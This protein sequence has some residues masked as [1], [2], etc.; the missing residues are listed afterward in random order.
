MGFFSPLVVVVVRVSGSFHG[1]PEGGGAIPDKEPRSEAGG[2]VGAGGAGIGAGAGLAV[3][4]V[5]VAVDFMLADGI[6]VEVG[7]EAV[8]HGEGAGI[9]KLCHR[10]NPFLSCR[11]ML[12]YVMEREREMERQF[13]ARARPGHP[14][15]RRPPLAGGPT[16]HDMPHALVYSRAIPCGWPGGAGAA[17]SAPASAPAPAPAS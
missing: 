7:G 10:R 2:G 11:V 3:G 13:V 1:I 5:G 16:L 14:P 9:G 6:V 12:C 8:A 4:D 15:S 17:G